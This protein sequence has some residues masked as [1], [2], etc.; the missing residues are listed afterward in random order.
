MYTNTHVQEEEL[1]V[2]DAAC[3]AQNIQVNIIFRRA[4]IIFVIKQTNVK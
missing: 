2:T 4:A 1:T 3:H